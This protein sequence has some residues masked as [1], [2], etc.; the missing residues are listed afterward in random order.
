[1]DAT[2]SVV[3]ELNVALGT[4]YR[5]VRRLTGGLQ[6]SAYVLADGDAQVILKWNEDPA[7]APRVRLAAD[8]VRR[9]R[10]V[11]YP[12]PEWFVVG[13]TAS[14][15]PYQLQEFVDGIPLHDASNLDESLTRQLIEVVELQ[16]DL[17]PEEGLSW[18][19]YSRGVV[20]DDWDGLWDRVRAYGGEAAELLHRYDVLCRPYRDH[21]MPDNDLV[22]GDLNVGNLIV[23]DGR[24]AG[25]VDIEAAGGGSRAYDLISLAASAARDGSPPG[26][27]ELFLEAALQATDHATVAISAASAYASVA[28]FVQRRTPTSQ[29]PIHH[30]AR[31]LLE[32]LDS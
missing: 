2:E 25:I 6:S 19:A 24:I 22:H 32:L 11:G 1:M 17:V 16:R 5:L 9:A 3:A 14:G 13:T 20:F 28:E 12:T 27:D 18:S 23:N 7:W 21:A 15:S 30:G 26:L 31:R 10:A 8:L 4:D 29:S